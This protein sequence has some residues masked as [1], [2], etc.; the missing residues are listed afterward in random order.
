[1]SRAKS[2]S[3]QNPEDAQIKDLAITGPDAEIYDVTDGRRFFYYFDESPRPLAEVIQAGA[4]RFSL[5]FGRSPQLV[6]LSTGYNL[7]PNELLA[8]LRVIPL[9]EVPL[10]H[11]WFGPKPPYYQLQFD[12]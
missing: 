8:G 2:N 1:M 5:K 3:S 12:L 11:F 10:A 9:E 7:K 4:F 6:L